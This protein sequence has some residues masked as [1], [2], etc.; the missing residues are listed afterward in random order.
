LCLGLV[1]S[2]CKTLT[3]LYLGIPYIFKNQQ[4]PLI[5]IQ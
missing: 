3:Q 4:I 5:K 2:N 1:S